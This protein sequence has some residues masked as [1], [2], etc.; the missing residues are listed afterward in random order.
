M[1]KPTQSGKPGRKYEDAI[2]SF[3]PH[4]KTKE[5]NEEARKA[6]ATSYIPFSSELE[7]PIF[8]PNRDPK[9]IKNYFQVCVVLIA[10]PQIDY[11]QSRKKAAELACHADCHR[12]LYC[13]LY[14]FMR[15]DKFVAKFSARFKKV[16]VGDH[17]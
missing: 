5:V 6:G 10:W 14:E 2:K 8:S 12:L 4:D 17:Q 9:S 7:R 16:P 11:G 3:Q 15:H 13:G 1:R